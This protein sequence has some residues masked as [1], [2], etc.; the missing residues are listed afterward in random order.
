MIRHLRPLRAAFTLV[1][2]LVVIAIIGVL[3]AL[4]LPAVQ[5]AREAAR[6]VQCSNNLKQLGLALHSF[7]AARQQFPPAGEN[8]GWCQYPEL[9]Q[10][11]GVLNL[12]GMIR[13]L[14]Y[15]EQQTLYEQIDLRQTTANLNQGNPACCQPNKA[16]TNLMGDAVVSGNAQ[17]VSNR[18]ES[19]LCPSDIG[20]L[21]TKNNSLYGIGDT[22]LSGAKTNYDF[23]VF[24]S[25]EC[26]YWAR[27]DSEKR[28]M[29][30]ENSNARAKSVTDGL[31]NTV[32]M[33]ETLRDVYDGEGPAWGY[34][35]WVMVG[36]DLPMFEI[37]KWLA[38]GVIQEP[39]R[40]QLRAWGHG[41]SLHGDGLQV[42]MAD[43]SV[44]YL[45]ESTDRSVL[46]LLVQ[47][48]DYQV[49]EHPF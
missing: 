36:V 5:N 32:A 11:E 39:R 16:L 15:L 42:L 13:L 22:P 41:G 18:L 9:R 27:Q 31:S 19:L 14:P 37:N 34:R 2:L 8:Y 30:G 25:Y 35:G 6:R 45:L 7:H 38:P 49:Y 28:R 46:R 40:S 10:I 17:A 23:S 3:L 29:F 1:E 24:G 20:E 21:Y 43:G 48:A 26:G 47:M 33:V 4:L 44:Q 12:N